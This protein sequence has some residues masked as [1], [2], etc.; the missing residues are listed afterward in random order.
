MAV[1]WRNHRVWRHAHLEAAHL[2]ASASLPQVP[3]LDVPDADDLLGAWR[4]ALRSEEHTSELQSQPNLVCRLLLEEK[5]RSADTV[6]AI[7]VRLALLEIKLFSARRPR[8]NCCHS[9]ER[10]A[11]CSS[12][13]INDENGVSVL[14]RAT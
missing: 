4:M 6:S 5:N 3:N 1:R 9:D 10:L 13:G 11:H 14:C 8:A 12:V 2:A 7:F